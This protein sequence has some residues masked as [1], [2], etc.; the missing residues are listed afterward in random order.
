MKQRALSVDET[1]RRI[2]EATVRLHGTLGPAQTSIGIR[3]N[4]SSSAQYAA[5]ASISSAVYPR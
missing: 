2:V 3:N 1:R 5:N 4:R